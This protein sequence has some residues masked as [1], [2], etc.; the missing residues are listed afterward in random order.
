[1]HFEWGVEWDDGVIV[2][3]DEETARY[4]QQ[5]PTRP[6]HVNPVLVWRRVGDWEAAK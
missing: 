6:D 2:Y 5:Y 1:M 4:E 3:P